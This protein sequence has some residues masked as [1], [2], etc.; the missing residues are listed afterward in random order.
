MPTA[1]LF[2]TNLKALRDYKGQS[3]QD[4]ADALHIRRGRYA[5]W[6]Q[7]IS[8]PGLDNLLALGNHFN[9]RIELLLRMDLAAMNA[10]DLQRHVK[11]HPAILLF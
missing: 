7:G 4:V 10:F 3:Q 1:H 6:E 8:E 9:V 2:P 5:S 11:T